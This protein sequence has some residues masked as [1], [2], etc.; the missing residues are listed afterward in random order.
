MKEH[1]IEV[2]LATLKAFRKRVSNARCL[3]DTPKQA[4]ELT[5]MLDAADEFINCLTKYL[6]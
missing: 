4:Y 1:E 6:Q 5:G 3:T 2:M